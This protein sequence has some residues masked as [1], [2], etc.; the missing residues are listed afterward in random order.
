VSS[1]VLVLA[2]FI[3]WSVTKH[4]SNGIV[5]SLLGQLASLV[6]RV[7][8]LVVKDREVQCQTETDGVGGGKVGGSDFGS[9]L[10]GLERLV[11][12]SLALVTN[13]ELGKVAMVVALPVSQTWLASDLVGVGT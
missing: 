8:D 6:G 12:G 10:V 9:S 3:R 5:E 13:G 7:E 4:T 2:A 1:S 11:G